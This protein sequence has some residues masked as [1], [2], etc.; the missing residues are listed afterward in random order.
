MLHNAIEEI[1]GGSLMPNAHGSGAAAQGEAKPSLI[2]DILGAAL[3]KLRIKL[4]DLTNRNRLLNFRFSETSRKLVRVVDELPDELFRR[5]CDESVPAKKLFFAPL[6]EL[7][8]RDVV[9]STGSFRKAL[10]VAHHTDDTYLAATQ[11]AEQGQLDE[12]GARQAEEDLRASV[13][14]QFGPTPSG[15]STKSKPNM[16]EWARQHGIDP[17]YDLPEPGSGA[18]VGK[19]DDKLQTLLLP[20]ALERKLSGVREAAIL[21]EQELGLSTLYAAFGFLEWYEAPE[22]DDAKFAPLVLLPIKIDRELKRGL[23]RYFIEGGDGDAAVNLTLRERLRRD[24]QLELPDFEEDDTP[25]SYFFR[26]SALLTTHKRWRVRR[27]VVI[28]HFSFARLAMFEDL[29]PSKWAGGLEANQLLT[30][31]LIGSEP[32]D[33]LTATD[34]ELDN[35]EVERTVPILVTDADSSQF[36]A[37]LDAMSGRSFALKGPPGTGKSQTITNLIALALAKGKKVLFVA[38][39]MA[40]LEVVA[41]RLRDA[42]LGPFLLELHSTK[43]QKKKVL[44]S[45]E[46]RLNLRA[47]KP[48]LALNHTMDTLRKVRAELTRYVALM[49]SVVGKTG[50]TLHNIYWLEQRSRRELG[51]D[52]YK[53]ARRLREP[54][55]AEISDH[56]FTA[57]LD[58]LAGFA[59]FWKRCATEGGGKISSHPLVP[60]DCANISPVDHHTLLDDI[61]AWAEFTE[62]FEGLRA[63]LA[64]TLR[65]NLPETLSAANVLCDKLLRLPDA[66]T[67]IDSGLLSLASRKETF[68][69]LE[70]AAQHIQQI[71][72]SERDLSLHFDNVPLLM[73]NLSRLRGAAAVVAEAGAALPVSEQVPPSALAASFD[74]EQKKTARVLDSLELAG[75]VAAAADATETLT[76]S[77]LDCVVEFVGLLH[78]SSESAIRGRRESLYGQEAYECLTSAAQTATRLRNE[79]QRLSQL[80]DFGK[81]EPAPALKEFATVL[82]GT[83]SILAVF[84]TRCRRARQYFSFITNGKKA[85]RVQVANSFGELASLLGQTSNFTSDEQLKRVAGASLRGLATEFESLLGANDLATRARRRFSSLNARQQGYQRLLLLGEA[86]F[87]VDIR[88]ALKPED[89]KHVREWIGDS[90]VS[91][92]ADLVA[93]ARERHGLAGRGA[94]SATILAGIALRVSLSAREIRAELDI[95][96]SLT[97]LRKSLGESFVAKHARLSVPTLSVADGERISQALTVAKEIFAFSLPPD[98]TSI[99]LS[100]N[101]AAAVAGLKKAAD[102]I[103]RTKERYHEFPAQLLARYGV[104]VSNI[105]DENAK[106]ELS[107]VGVSKRLR[108]ASSVGENAVSSWANY[109][110]L[111][112]EAQRRQLAFVVDSVHAGEISGELA[113]RAYAFVHFRSLIRSIHESTAELSSWTGEH[114]GSLRK[115]LRSLDAEYLE[116]GQQWLRSTL[117]HVEIPKGNARGPKKEWTDR[118]LIENEIPKQKK[119][120]SIRKL[121][122]RALGAALSL[123]PCFMMSPASVAQFMPQKRG[124]F[125]LVVIDEASQM[126][127]EEAVGCVARG[128]QVIVVGDPMQLPPTSFFDSVEID[129]G[130]TDEEQFDV[131]AESVLD[132]ALA[133]LRPH[134]ELRWHYR[135]KHHSLIAFSNREFYQGNL[136]VFPSPAEQSSQVGIEYVHVDNGIYH[137]S[138]N[139]TEADAVVAQVAELMIARPQDSIGV[140]AINQPQRELL[141]ELFDRRF[142]EDPSLEEYRLRHAESLEPFFIKNLENVQGDERDVIV[143]STVY[144][145]SRAGGPVFQRFGP[146]NSKTGHRRLNVLFTRAKKRVVLI[147]SLRSE[148]IQVAPGSSPG[149]VA[150]KGYLEFA[151]SGRLDAGSASDEDA[152]DSPFEAEVADVLRQAGYKVASQV[153]VAGYFL[154][155]AVRHPSNP[156][157]FILGVECDGATYHSARCARDRDKLRQQVLESLGWNIFRIWSTD[158]FSDRPREVEKLRSYLDR[159]VR[160]HGSAATGN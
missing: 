78:Q 132:Q 48:D 14:K 28:G 129:D 60:F 17:S 66:R 67:G 63:S 155:L 139:P 12:E 7:E 23:Y 51:E 38:E 73:Q 61:R 137:A 128:A 33:S 77:E 80:F 105:A 76:L 145:P 25:E 144:G 110:R 127:P 93:V 91:P 30:S 31:L 74:D 111:Q 41:K 47:P 16:A 143:I 160:P 124:A 83:H 141:S 15:D 34:Y 115:R 37:L 70:E 68:V 43:V 107:L 122:E 94:A 102:L 82:R 114:L 6:P 32:G 79:H 21:A 156:D 153:G 45:F 134:R 10:D 20:D 147:S 88:D 97:A 58:V 101:Y 9:E 24:F 59:E 87:L 152:F 146:I 149:V 138:V 56:V 157:H 40:A 65:C 112:K 49:N 3:E 46:E 120:L 69:E 89:I 35:E 84:S 81:L 86:Q 92:T 29:A 150:F 19:D 1:V 42:K 96:H 116:R 27:F 158:W 104:R 53:V 106:A 108:L 135:S 55:A 62:K 64:N 154:D 148:D 26:V 133:R 57:R 119:V 8:D 121:L 100:S 140:V 44:Q 125:D 126:R 136:I 130:M 72:M 75:R 36:S 98:V 109:C 22:S 151:R 11:A 18:R 142:A 103:T 71:L 118:A 5:L 159:L 123:K 90:G 50:T 2:A 54:D 117:A 13:R 131:D 85:T 39:K 95:A 4:L 113:A 52:G 99:I